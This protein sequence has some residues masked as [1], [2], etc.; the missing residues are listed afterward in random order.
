LGAGVVLLRTEGD[1][2]AVLAV[3]RAL[4]RHRRH[5]L[6]RE[7]ALLQKRV[8]KRLDLTAR[9]FFALVEPGSA[10]AGSLFELALAADRSYM[11]AG[12]DPPAALALSPLN[13]GA[14]PTSSGLSRLEARFPEDPTRLQE[15][16]SHP[17]PFAVE[18]AVELGLVTFAPDDID[19]EDE[20][21]LA[22]EERP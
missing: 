5:W 3:D 13:H 14:L 16:L 7:I 6:V 18:A 17:G 4:D 1:P 9:T 15:V 11:L 21:R 20:I 10:F 12:G 2:E 22:I 8:L 19:W